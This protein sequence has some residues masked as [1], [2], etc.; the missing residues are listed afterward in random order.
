[1]NDV[2]L[3]QFRN[4]SKSYVG[5]HALRNLSFDIAAGEV[6]AVCGENG[7]GKSTLIRL[8]TGVTSPEEGEILVEGRQLKTGNV[9]CSEDA[10]IA[11]M[12]QESSIFPD[13]NA[14]DNIFVGRE[15]TWCSGWLLDRAQ[16]RQRTKQLLDRLGASI[17]MDLPVGELPLAQQQMIALAR[18]LSR[19]CR[20]LIMDEPTASLSARETE[21]LLN[22]VRQLRADGVSILYV[23]HRLEE[24]FEI[25]DRVTVL[26]DGQ[27]VS[28]HATTEL[29]IA[30]LIQL[31]VGRNI[32]AVHHFES[33]AKGAPVLAVEQLTREGAFRDV[34]F[35]IHNGEIVGLAGLVGSGRSEIARAI[36]G[37]D[38]FESGSIRVES[39]LL[40]RNSVRESMA[41][42]IAL[43]PED[44]QREGLVLE[45]TVA[46]NLSLATLPSLCRWGFV[47]RH[48]EESLANEFMSRLSIKAAAPYVA[49][50][51]LSGG[52]QQKIVLG[53]WLA[54][55]PK[56]LILDEPT[57]GVDVGAKAQVHQIVRELAKSGMATL[58]I[59]SEMQELLALCDRLLVVRDGRIVGEL[60]CASATQEEILALALPDALKE[61]S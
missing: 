50:E 49:A 26:R 37:I 44:R 11:V 2:P 47:N 30:K 1:V 57:R 9:Q 23:S 61:T 33:T 4:L 43:V 16:M 40:R 28:T 36:F 20:L 39:Q 8:L 27:Y 54:H 25:S 58:V 3:L 55:R 53:K 41:A 52:N 17:D 42:G 35:S 19:D 6:H 13:L 46:E 60:S 59:S 29:D 31:M 48:H 7:A 32:E 5:V 45:M 34:T 24:V 18:A 15:I 14:V 10:G 56:V 21:T 51:T 22:I 12:H 38:G